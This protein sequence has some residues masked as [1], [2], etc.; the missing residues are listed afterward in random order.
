MKIYQVIQSQGEWEDYHEWVIYTT[1]DRAK[2]EYIKRRLV[3]DEKVLIA[4]PKWKCWFEP[5]N[6][7]ID[8]HNVD[9]ADDSEFA[10][11]D[12]MVNQRGKLKSSIFG[13]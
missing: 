10:F 2:A 12:T 9:K 1:T 6:F 8:T 13:D 3:A 5:S 11:L 7:R 4:R